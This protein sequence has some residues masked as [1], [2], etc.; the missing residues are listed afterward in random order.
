[1]NRLRN[2]PSL[3]VIVR[4]LPFSCTSEDLR[5]LCIHLS[6][7][8]PT[9][10]LVQCDAKQRSLHY[11]YLMFEET[12]EVEEVLKC[13]NGRRYLGR[14]IR[15][16]RFEVSAPNQLAKSGDI[17]VYFRSIRNS[18]PRIT[19]ETIRTFLERYGEIT[20]VVI[21]QYSVDSAGKQEGFGF[22][23]FR[24]PSI[25]EHI[26][27]TVRHVCFDGASFDCSWSKKYLVGSGEADQG[28]PVDK[29]DDLG[30]SRSGDDFIEESS[31]VSTANSTG[32]PSHYQPVIYTTTAPLPYDAPPAM[33]YFPA[34]L[35]PGPAYLSHPPLY[36]PTVPANIAQPRPPM[37]VMHQLPNTPP[38]LMVPAQWGTPPLPASSSASPTSQGSGNVSVNYQTHNFQQMQQAGPMSS[39]PSFSSMSSS[40]PPPA[41]IQQLP[42]FGPPI[43]I[44]APY[45]QAS[46]QVGYEPRPMHS[47]PFQTYSP[48]SHSMP[49]HFTAYMPPAYP[50]T[51]HLMAPPMGAQM[52]P[53]STRHQAMTAAQQILSASPSPIESSMGQQQFQHSQPYM[54]P[55]NLQSNP[56]NTSHNA[57]RTRT[58]QEDQYTQ[59][60]R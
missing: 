53:R 12:E 37:M 6:G 4:D 1:M 15:A 27:A 40:P 51:S 2:N 38:P 16:A 31:S 36:Y 9:F 59:Q 54:H 46:P 47:P 42:V 19:E 41:F 44:P 28:S 60:F 18:L 56:E 20:N 43:M 45:T 50:A 23:T 30:R 52:M 11:G 25:H 34:P 32:L 48:T 3:S 39:H 55:Q 8:T 17:H 33:A 5:D 7:R 35:I 26:A 58:P 22:V 29:L 24:D 10:A 49:H 13:M 57:V 21:R 14:D